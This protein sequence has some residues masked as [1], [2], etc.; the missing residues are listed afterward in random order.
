VAE[1]KPAAAHSEVSAIDG[2]MY[3]ARGPHWHKKDREKGLVPTGLRN[4][5]TESIWTAHQDMDSESS[6]SLG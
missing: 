1:V 5:D 4:V 2:R 6:R 3:K